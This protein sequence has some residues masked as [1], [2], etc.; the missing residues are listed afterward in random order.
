MEFIISN[1]NNNNTEGQEQEKLLQAVANA[2]EI[3][4]ATKLLVTSTRSLS[5]SFQGESFSLPISKTKSVNS[6]SNS[7]NSTNTNT[8]G[9]TNARKATPEK[10]RSTPL[11]GKVDGSG[12]QV[13]NSNM[14][15][16]TNS[17]I[18]AKPGDQQRWPARTRNNGDVLNGIRGAMDENLV[19]E[20]SI[21]SD[22][23]AS[24]T[25]SVS[26]GST[27][28]AQE[29]NS[30]SHGRSS[31]GRGI[32]VSAKFW[33]E[34]NMRLRRLQDPGL[35]LTP[36]P[37]S[38]LVGPPKLSQ[39]RKFSDGPMS[40]PRA[41]SSPIRGVV[42]AASPSKLV[43]TPATSP[44]KDLAHLGRGK[45]GENR[46]VDAHQLRL[47]YN[48]HLQWRFVNAR[49]DAALSVQRRNAELAGCKTDIV[50]K[51]EI[52]TIGQWGIS[53]MGR[54]CCYYVPSLCFLGYPTIIGLELHSKVMTNEYL[55]LQK[56]FGLNEAVFTGLD[57]LMA[58]L[59][60][61]TSL[62]NLWNAWITITA[63][64]DAVRY[65]RTQLQLLRQKLKLSSILRGQMVY[66]EDW[67]LLDDDHSN[68][69]QGAIEALKAST[70]RL[71]V[72]GGATADIQSVKEAVGSAV[73]VMQS[74]A[75]STCSVLTK[76]EEVNSLVAELSKVA[77]KERILLE[78]SKEVLSMLAAMQVKDCSLRTHTLQLN[79]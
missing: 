20:S 2:G 43:N 42:R 58:K 33:Q 34:T 45:V 5:V 72:V 17:N 52:T 4:A 76:V 38:K 21:P 40:S 46:I 9:N 24:D 44:M 8:N 15:T 61:S 14:N 73:D 78:K 48:R 47:L 69:L 12:D 71:P 64:R 31:G 67:S 63:L 50:V 51:H 54:K 22:L 29:M 1:N 36:S 27:S 66:L 10:R 74:M 55:E 49:A 16:N 75:S 11:R 65:K 79:R 60:S 19:N 6:G 7:N 25:D 68:A 28:G 18:N 70:L 62:K 23:T 56:M 13:D 59:C 3:S 30:G 77:S 32:M 26:S 35:G 53:M 37:T 41:M 57:F 39:S